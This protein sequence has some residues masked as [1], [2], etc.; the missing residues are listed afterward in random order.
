LKEAGTVAVLLP[1][2]SFFLGVDPAPGRRLIEASLPV[3][4]ATDV[5]PGSSMV[6]SLAL[7]LSIACTQMRLTPAE[8]LVA[9]TANAAAALDRHAY[10]GAIAPNMQA[11]LLV[12][13]VPSLEQWVYHVGRPC[14]RAVIKRGRIVVGGGAVRIEN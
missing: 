10:L 13:N 6:E 4:I 8:A 5:N 1:A 7:T 14:V 12:L 2:C 11:D 3:A 9:A